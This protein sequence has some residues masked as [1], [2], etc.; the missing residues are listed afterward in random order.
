MN[1]SKPKWFTKLDIPGVYSLI[2]MAEGEE[3]ITAFGTHYGLSESLVMPFGLTNTL[4][5]FQYYIN[6]VLVPYLDCFCTTYLDDILIYSDTFE[7]YQ[8]HIHLVLD[9][10]TK[11]SLHLK[12]K[13]CELHQQEV[14]YL[15]LSISMEG[16]KMD[17]KRIRTMQDCEPPSNSIDIHVFL[18]FANFYCY[19]IRNYSRI[20]QPCTFL[21]HKGVPFG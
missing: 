13:K 5:T 1:L 14:N 3:W 15:G 16:I 2:C 19:F 4:A 12:P 20:V 10:F 9:A 11:V 18:A 6:D 7:E 8:Q 21:T 17:P